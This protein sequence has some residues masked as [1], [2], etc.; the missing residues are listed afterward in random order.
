M[1]LSG[2]E[3]DVFN[4]NSPYLGGTVQEAFPDEQ[5]SPGTSPSMGENHP[6]VFPAMPGSCSRGSL[7]GSL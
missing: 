4:K 3:S 1:E 7:I 6:C 2:L 5:C